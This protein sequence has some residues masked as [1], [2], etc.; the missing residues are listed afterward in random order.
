MPIWDAS[1][2]GRGFMYS[3]VSLLSFP[4]SDGPLRAD[5]LSLPHTWSTW[6]VESVRVFQSRSGVA[7]AIPAIF[8]RL[9]LESAL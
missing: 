1:T 8:A 4:N 3:A 6:S 7:P 5:C 9:L 2:I